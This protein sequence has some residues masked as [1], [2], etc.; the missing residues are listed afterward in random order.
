MNLLTLS[1]LSSSDIKELIS[2]IVIFSVVFILIYLFRKKTWIHGLAMFAFFWSLYFFLFYFFKILPSFKIGSKAVYNTGLQEY[3]TTYTM[4][5]PH[6][7]IH[8][9]PIAFLMACIALTWLLGDFFL[10]IMK[11]DEKRK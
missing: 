1:R 3:V 5:Y 9:Y 4:F 8:N 7:F 2:G 11:I 10:K 6:K